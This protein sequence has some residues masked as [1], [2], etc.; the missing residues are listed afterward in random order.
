MRNSPFSILNVPPLP[1]SKVKRSHLLWSNSVPSKLSPHSSTAGA[2]WDFG[3]GAGIGLFGC[4]A[5]EAT[6]ARQRI[7][8][9][10]STRERLDIRESSLKKRPGLRLEAVSAVVELQALVYLSEKN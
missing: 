7:V 4:W 9:I 5:A 10:K 6:A 3:D 2:A 8:A 1:P